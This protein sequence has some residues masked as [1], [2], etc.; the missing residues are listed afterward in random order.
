MD[1]QSFDFIS[2][3]AE[4][5]QF[6]DAF[7]PDDCGVHIEANAICRPEQLLDA[8]LRRHDADGHQRQRL[9]SR[10][11]KIVLDAVEDKD[12]EIWI[13]SKEKKLKI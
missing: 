6:I 2:F 11:L 3:S 8:L 12:F 5:S 9:Q 7:V 13:D 4:I 10:E 1:L